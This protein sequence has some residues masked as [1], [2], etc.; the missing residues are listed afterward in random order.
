MLFALAASAGD[1]ERQARELAEE[2]L[3]SRELRVRVYNDWQADPRAYELLSVPL[4]GLSVRFDALNKAFPA[5]GKSAVI[6]VA[7]QDQTDQAVRMVLEGYV[8]VEPYEEKKTLS[9]WPRDLSKPQSIETCIFKDSVRQPIPNAE[10]EIWMGV[11]P[12]LDS[13]PRV[14]VAKVKLDE[15]G[16]LQ[17]PRFISS[18]RT[19]FIVHH[20]DCGPILARY[21]SRV[22]RD[23]PYKWF[24][25]PALPKD[26]WCTFTDAIG[27]PIPNATVEIFLGRPWGSK[28][29]ESLG[30]AKLDEEG[31]LRPPRSNTRL[32][33]CCFTISHPEYGTAMVDPKPNSALDELV[34]NC[35]VP[36]VRAGS[37][38]DERSI[39]GT[40]VDPNGNPVAGAMIMCFGVRTPGG[41]NI[42]MPDYDSC[43]A[44]TY[45][46]G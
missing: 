15:A 23:E 37:K 30:K 27:E 16:V 6:V 5:I 19:C 29:P 1:L 22:S 7:G 34:T 9:I 20:P 43:R 2:T 42:Q 39:W 25:V 33:Y 10:V 21:V 38:A 12:Y 31:R 11:D 44:V 8:Y 40:I 32:E 28:V 18:W 46:Q 3:T 45:Q 24:Q 13:G 17:P 41:G 4:D 36:L 14:M 26:K 35:T